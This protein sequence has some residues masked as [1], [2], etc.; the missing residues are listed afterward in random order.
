MLIQTFSKVLITLD[1][2]ANK[3]FIAEF[4]CI[5]KSKPQLQCQGHCFLKKQLKKAEQA[6]QQTAGS[7]QKKSGDITLFCQPLFSLRPEGAGSVPARYASLY[8]GAASGRLFAVF[9][10]PQFP[11]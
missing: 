4:L 9:H 2:E 10:P 3:A 7:N 5:N 8:P 11:V 6:E 1:Y